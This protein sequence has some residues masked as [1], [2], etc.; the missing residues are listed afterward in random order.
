MADFAANRRDDQ[1]VAVVGLGPI[2]RKVVEALDKGI[3]GL[4][5]AAVSVQE[6]AKIGTFWPG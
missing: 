4:V 6:P 5:L 3:D 1:R 2:G